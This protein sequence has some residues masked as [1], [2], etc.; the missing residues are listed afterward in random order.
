[1]LT[2]L[3][4]AWLTGRMTNDTAVYT[5]RINFGH[6]ADAQR[7]IAEIKQCG[8]KFDPATKQWSVD[9]D[10][11]PDYLVSLWQTYDYHHGKTRAQIV[12]DQIALCPAAELM[13]SK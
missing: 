11:T 7:A 3:Q 13:P 5:Y 10:K 4:L 8:G 12:A 1:V 2:R 6:R 9:P